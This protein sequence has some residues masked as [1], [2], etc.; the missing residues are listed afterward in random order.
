MPAV[1][2]S[3][4]TVV[5]DWHWLLFACE[6]CGSGLTLKD[7][8]DAAYP[9]ML[10]NHTH[11]ETRESERLTVQAVARLARRGAA[12]PRAK[13]AFSLALSKTAPLIG[14][15]KKKNHEQDKTQ[16]DMIPVLRCE[17]LPRGDLDK[18]PDEDD[19]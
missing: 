1:R 10:V 7:E 17:N 4:R 15:K 3:W 13:A 11:P 18:D 5:F 14:K 9:P 2:V 12:R 16:S 19:R 8:D 6:V